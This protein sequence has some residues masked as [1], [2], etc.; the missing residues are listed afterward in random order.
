MKASDTTKNLN[1]RIEYLV[2]SLYISWLRI[3]YDALFF[4]L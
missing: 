4:H 3:Y 2:E 1:A